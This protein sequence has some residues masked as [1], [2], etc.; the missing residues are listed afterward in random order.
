MRN[1]K[2]T[3]LVIGKFLPLHDGHEFLISFAKHFVDQLFVVVDNI[4]KRSYGNSYI[5]GETR[6]KWIQKKFPGVKVLYLPKEMPQAPNEHKR[7][8]EI[9]KKE[10]QKILKIR[11]DYILA[12]ETY[13]FP[14]AD[15]LGSKF[16]P[17]DIPRDNTGVSGTKIRN[18]L[19][20]NWNHLSSVAKANFV[21]KFCIFGPE[22]SGKT[23]IAK[24]LA[25]HFNG[26]FVPEYARSYLETH[27]DHKKTRGGNFKIDFDDMIKIARGQ[28]AIEDATI[29]KAEKMIFCDT[30]Q[31][32][33]DI[34]TKWLFKDRHN[35]EIGELAKKR[36]YDLCLLLRP[37]IAW[38][39]DETRYTAQQEEREKFFE[40]CEKELIDHGRRY[41]IISGRG[42]KRNKMAISAVKK[43]LEKNFNYQYFA[44]KLQ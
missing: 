27:I 25:K 21:M 13:G 35:K 28:G 12:S 33:T 23:T 38:K 39:H 32:T 18:D 37:D 40:Q 42:E 31:L 34:W 19:L 14:L 16:I 1:K 7:F 5:P 3:G 30:D 29:S 15:I 20:H 11:P 24:K 36:N 8:W 41:A 9:W 2:T 44:K 43:F 4:P 26:A 6:V 22:S 10:L 17:I